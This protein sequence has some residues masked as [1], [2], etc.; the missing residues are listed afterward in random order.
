MRTASTAHTEKA[1]HKALFEMIEDKEH[2]KKPIHALIPSDKFVEFN[3]ATTYFHGEGLTVIS[4][5][6]GWTE[7]KNNG[8]VCW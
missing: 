5:S 6:D 4:I 8:Y 7:V 2:W 3:R 1:V